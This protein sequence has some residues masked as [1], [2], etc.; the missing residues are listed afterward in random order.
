MKICFWGNIASALNGKTYG[1]GE[2]QIA[3]LA[4]ALAVAGHEVIVID[5][6]VSEDLITKEG[7][8]VYKINGWNKGIP[9]LRTIT[10]RLPKLYQS[11]KAQ[12]ADVYYCRIRDFRHILAY[13]A[14]RK[15]KAKF[16]LGL[17]SN[18]DISGFP[19]RFK[20]QYITSPK[21]LWN[22]FSS[23]MIEMVQPF[24]IKKADYILVQHVNQKKFLQRKNIRSKILPNLFDN[25]EI[26]NSPAQ[27]SQ[28]F[29]HVGAL[30]KRKGFIDF[31]KLIERTPFYQYKIIGLPRDKSTLIYYNK[32][33]SFKN[34]TLLGRLKH[35]KVIQEISHSKAL[36]F[37]SPME[38]FP[39]VFIE[40]WACGIP[41]LS[42]FF[43]PG[44]IDQERLGIVAN[45]NLERLMQEMETISNSE[46][47]VK[48]SR[49][50]VKKYHV[51][52]KSKIEEI[53]QI[54]T[55]ILNYPG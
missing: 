38:G 31:F 25:P 2:W 27:N 45:G 4:K 29:I 21:N 22:L 39:N 26:M 11:L 51:L 30:D 32:L 36:I 49:S 6:N 18:L 42:L 46:E 1:G 41:V 55:E 19:K 23:I 15:A 7:I 47:F 44:V 14:A 12:K 8:H 17:A 9:I 16:V 20:Y 43:D 28:Y 54:F 52:D 40:A 50:Y 24:L 48:R 5:Y 53:D 33:K 35:S 34:V 3:L 13:W 37:T 10:H